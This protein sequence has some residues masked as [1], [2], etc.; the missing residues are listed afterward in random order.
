[1]A[2]VGLQKRLRLRLEYIHPG[3]RLR[4]QHTLTIRGPGKQTTR[5]QQHN[6]GTTPSH[7][8]LETRPKGPGVNAAD[9]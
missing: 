5:A 6:H 2:K 4:T 1:M 7:Q 9:R 3:Y 8:G